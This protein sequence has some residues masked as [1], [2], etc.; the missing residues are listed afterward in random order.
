MQ[1]ESA[2][3]EPSTHHME[4]EPTFGNLLH[5]FWARR[6]RLISIFLVSAG[7]LCVG[8]L[9][10]R[11]VIARAVIEGTLDMSFRGIERHEYPS[12]KKFSIEDIR[13]PQ[14]LALARANAGLPSGTAVQDLYVGVEIAPVIPSEVQARWRKQDRDGAKREEFFPREFRIRVHPKGLTNDQSAQFLSALVKA[15]QDEARSARAMGRKDR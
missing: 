15:Y 11:L 10:W 2:P 7:L 3:H 12:G 5:F 9:F 13:S 4:A 1:A 6:V 14:V 8:L